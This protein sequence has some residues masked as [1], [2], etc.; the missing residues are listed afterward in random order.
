MFQSIIR[1]IT[2]RKKAE[3]EM[4]KTE[5]LESLSI[6]AGGI[7]H[8]FNNIL[9]GILGNISLA[10]INVGEGNKIAK[11][12]VEAENA[13][14][15]AKSLTQQLLTFAKGGLPVKNVI[16]IAD[17]IR[18][19]ASFALRGSR[20]KCHFSIARNLWTVAVD[21]GQMSQVIN[22]LIIN[23]DM[24]MPDGGII[25]IDAQNICLTEENPLPLSEGRYIMIGISDEGIGI[26]KDHLSKIFDP[27]FTT[28]QKGSGLGL[29]TSYSIVKK[30]NGHMV[31]DSVLG[32]GTTFT[33]YLPA[34]EKGAKKISEPRAAKLK[35]SSKILI[36][37][38]DETIRNVLIKMLG[39]IGCQAIATKDGRETVKIYQKWK[40]A[41]KPFDA[42]IMDLTVPG[43]MGGRETIKKLR[44]IDPDVKA[45]VSSGY[46]NDPI[47]ANYKNYGFKGFVTK[48]FKLEELTKILKQV[49]T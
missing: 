12:L 31:V 10:K 6:L 43:G 15:R 4:Q 18:D 9:T 11:I 27:Y 17:L 24:A 38:D 42:V 22:N 19:S 30:H 29:A 40:Q 48:P 28:K 33:I 47:I 37:D 26:K 34:A 14:I 20:V 2:D 21:E 44:K 13:A 3:E 25:T 49:I 39:H 45:I 23:A 8:D 16:S 5:K 46:S 35:S 32:S 41:K 7:A 36:M 1:D